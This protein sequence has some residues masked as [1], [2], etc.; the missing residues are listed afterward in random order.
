MNI[1]VL[2][3]LFVIVFGMAAALSPLAR[4]LKDALLSSDRDGWEPLAIGALFVVAG[5]FTPDYAGARMLLVLGVLSA[6]LGALIS[7]RDSVTNAVLTPS[8]AIWYALLAVA[9]YVFGA[10]WA[11]PVAYNMHTLTTL[12]LPVAAATIFVTLFALAMTSA[13][14]KERLGRHPQGWY[15]AVVGLVVIALSP[16]AALNPALIIA[17]AGLGAMLM[18]IGVMVAIPDPVTMMYLGRRTAIIYVLFA[19]VM[20]VLARRL[21]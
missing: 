19:A 4:D 2:P 12:A 17:T 18:T 10:S 11:G 7:V 16:F 15:L 6:M 8:L 20:L 5:I 21:Y 14:F 9:S 13:T 3:P 1:Y